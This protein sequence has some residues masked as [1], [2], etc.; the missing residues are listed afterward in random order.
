MRALD[1]IY[2]TFPIV[3]LQLYNVSAQPK[4]ISVMRSVLPQAQ[5]FPQIVMDDLYIGGYDDLAR[6]VQK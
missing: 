6:F 3:T 1:L 4:L 5:T 2:K